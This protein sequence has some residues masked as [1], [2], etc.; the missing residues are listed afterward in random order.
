MLISA[1]AVLASAVASWVC[2]EV[3]MTGIFTVHNLV[4]VSLTP[5]RMVSPVAFVIDI[6]VGWKCAEQPLS[7]Y[8]PTDSKFPLA[9]SGKTLATFAAGFTDGML[10][11]VICVDTMSAP[12]GTITD[13]LGALMVFNLLLFIT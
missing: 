6:L 12:V 4:D 1:L 11:I 3:P 2:P 7:Q 10:N 8:C 9:R 5:F 13:S